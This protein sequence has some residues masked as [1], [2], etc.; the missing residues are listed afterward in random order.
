MI[1]LLVMEFYLIMRVQKE[2]RLLLLE[3]LPEGLQ[4]LMKV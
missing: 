2:E 3:K 4:E 1:Y